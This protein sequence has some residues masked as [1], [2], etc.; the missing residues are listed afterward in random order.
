MIFRVFIA[1]TGEH[2]NIT[3]AQIIKERIFFPLLLKAWT[4]KTLLHISLFG[5]WNNKGKDLLPPSKLKV[6][7]RLAVQN[8]NTNF[9]F[10]KFRS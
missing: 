2:L 9:S 7:Y 1:F 8:K 5:S 3:L 10:F 4:T 6:H